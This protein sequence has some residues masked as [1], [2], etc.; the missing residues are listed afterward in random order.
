VI[1]PPWGAQAKVTVSRTRSTRTT[2]VCS[3]AAAAGTPEREDAATST[4]SRILQA[5][6]T[7]ALLIGSGGTGDPRGG[8]PGA[9]ATTSTKDLYKR[10]RAEPELA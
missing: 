8:R 9:T 10:R 1:L 6:L 3:A 2:C 4:A 5:A 7:G